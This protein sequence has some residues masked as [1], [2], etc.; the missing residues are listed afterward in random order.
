[1]SG[2]RCLSVCLS[3]AML[4]CLSVFPSASIHPSWSLSNELSG[5]IHSSLI[6]FVT[7]SLT[8]CFVH[9]ITASA[10]LPLYLCFSLSIHQ[11]VYLFAGN[12][13]NTWH[14]CDSTWWFASA[15]VHIPFSFFFISVYT[16]CL[17]KRFFCYFTQSKLFCHQI[18][19]IMQVLWFNLHEAAELSKVKYVVF[20][21][22]RSLLVFIT[23]KSVDSVFIL[24]LQEN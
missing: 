3:H 2:C 18:N 12:G 1:V 6:L 5:W 10:S 15:G 9:F 4:A 24:K 7:L 22:T 19:C 8:V 17:K 16:G 23:F 13:L 14:C 21:R 11:S 20:V